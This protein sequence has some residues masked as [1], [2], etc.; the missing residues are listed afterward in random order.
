MQRALMVSI[1][2]VCLVA[3]SFAQKAAISCEA[4]KQNWDGTWIALKKI[5]IELTG[6]TVML[7]EGDRFGS[8]AIIINGVDLKTVLDKVC[9]E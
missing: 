6:G 5:T 7:V 1:V 9:A 2:L 8:H 3:P 4:F